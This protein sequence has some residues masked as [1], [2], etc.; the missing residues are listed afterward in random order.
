MNR[1]DTEE[2]YDGGGAFIPIRAIGDR[3]ARPVP[4]PSTPNPD[5][6][7]YENAPYGRAIRQL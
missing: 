7:G 5:S 3:Q 2:D 4:G 6:Y 1:W